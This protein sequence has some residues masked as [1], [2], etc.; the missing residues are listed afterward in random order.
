MLHR[1]RHYLVSISVLL[2]LSACG[3]G[4]GGGSTG[5]GATTILSGVLVFA[6]QANNR[7]VIGAGYSAPITTSS[8]SSLA[9]AATPK[10]GATGTFEYVAGDNITFSIG[11]RSYTVKAKG[12]IEIGELAN[13]NA[14]LAAN[15]KML[16]LNSDGDVSDGVDLTTGVLAADPSLSESEFSK[17][18]YKTLGKEPTL[19]FKPSLG[20]NL[21]S[22]QAEADTAG[23]AM[24]F[25]DVFRTA[26]PFQ[27]LSPSGTTFDSNGWPTSIPA[28]STYARSKLLQATTQGMLPSGEYTILYEGN[29]TL[30]L[31][32]S[33][34]TPTGSIAGLPGGTRG[35]T[36]NLNFV[37][38]SDAETNALGLLI[39]NISTGAGNY[40][41]N[42]R[43]IMPG[44][45]CK[46]NATGNYNSLVRVDSQADCPAS[47]TYTS[48]KD[49]L[50]TNR[51]EI[52]F[53]PD[54]LAVLKN[55]R[56]LRM[57]N[58]MDASPGI[59]HCRD[60]AGVIDNVCVMRVSSWVDRATL[61]DAVWGGSSRTDV[62]E[63]NGVP[64]EVL[65]ALANQLK[66]NP[67]FNIPHFAD[68][69]YVDGF[70]GYI[71]ANLDSNLKAYVE[72][73]NEIWNSG[74]IAFHYM[75]QKGNDAG[76]NTVPTAFS[77]TSRDAAYFARLRYYSKRAVE[78][79]DRWEAAFSGTSRLVRI[80]GT[81]QG[82][83]VLSEKV[84]EY[85]N[86]ATNGKVDALAMA[87]YFFGCID[88]TGSCASAPK[89]LSELSS[90]D[91]IFDIIDQPFTVDPSGMEGVIEKISRQA[92]VAQNHNVE[93]L[94]YEGG[95]HLTIMGAMGS[96]DAAKKASYRSLF[97]EANRDARMKVRY[98]T[99][100]DA[101]KGKSAQGAGLFTLYTLPQ[102]YYE[103]GNW[104]I[105][106]H[107][108]KSRSESPKFD[109]AMEFQE[110][111]GQCWWS[112]SDCS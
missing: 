87:P 21:E 100:L 109:A 59:S 78:I 89:V 43:I 46:D 66:I 62:I 11:G 57:M 104:G 3:G 41:K 79:F 14:S 92:T 69:T 98:K 7:V 15:L 68:D 42:I 33:V 95:Q 4:G 47:T 8:S 16:L 2:V 1:L 39:S 45:T 72:Y 13:G 81:S 17:A 80:L 6:Q 64:V 34:A 82:D 99:L 56:V 55:F 83:T 23:Q 75:E 48:F 54:Y 101:W 61:D 28:G 5:G 77:G 24:A 106:E 90:V 71:A 63:R 10:T 67:W 36:V 37:D 65:V 51:N 12:L 30:G 31:G 96:F 35:I 85:E 19:L 70:A 27:E 91:D 32:G 20:I 22:P 38:T 103:F 60:S 108:G 97:Q 40:I 93:L 29:G 102:T 76:F 44:G 105:K 50:L 94:A 88:R 18:L 110:S 84:L 25:V 53:N 73:S 86:A 74:F 9:A 52:I 26:R 111:Q 107:L 112:D 58:F 49:R